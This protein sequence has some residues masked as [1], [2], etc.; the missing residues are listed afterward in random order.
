MIPR[1]APLLLALAIAVAAMSG[2]SGAPAPAPTEATPPF[3]SEEEAFAAAEAT[4]REYVEALNDVDLSDPKTFEPVFALTTGGADAA[5]RKSLSQMHA[6]SWVV[7]G[8]SVVASVSRRTIEPSLE[9]AAL[10]ICLDV[11]RVRVVDESGGSVV[12]PDRGDVHAMRVTLQG[13]TAKDGT[14][15]ISTIAGRD[16]APSCDH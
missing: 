3:A 13:N 9:S 8:E 4:Y 1:R 2:C 6:D 12:E 16:G 5:I 7:S 10:D 11:S 14:W 15:K